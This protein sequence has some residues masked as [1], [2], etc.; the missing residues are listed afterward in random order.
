MP[1]I[2]E[3]DSAVLRPRELY[4]SQGRQDEYRKIVDTLKGE[5]V[6]YLQKFPA[7]R[8]RSSTRCVNPRLLDLRAIA[9]RR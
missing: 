5:R 6:E 3:S 2:E 1:G 7:L 4:E 9:G 8:Q